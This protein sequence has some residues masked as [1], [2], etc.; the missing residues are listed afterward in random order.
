MVAPTSLGL[1][2]LVLLA[3]GAMRRRKAG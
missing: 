1:L 3:L 2:G